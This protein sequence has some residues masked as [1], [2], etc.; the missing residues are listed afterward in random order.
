MDKSLKQRLIGAS[1]LIALA[2]IFVPMFLDSSGQQERAAKQNLALPE[3]EFKFEEQLPRAQ[4]L[5]SGTLPPSLSSSEVSPYPSVPQSTSVPVASS[6]KPARTPNELPAETVSPE[7]SKLPKPVAEPVSPIKPSK[8]RQKSPAVS[9]TSGWVVQVGSFRQRANAINLRN[10]LRHL[11]YT[12]FEN[13]IGSFYR[14][15]VGHES[16]RDQALALQA[17]LL[18]QQKLKGIVVQLR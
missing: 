16:E 7:V 18:A 2:I 3:P 13:K 8:S 9:A 11:G 5:G 14:V 10:S 1:V 4:D 12:V 15:H 17:K 6:P